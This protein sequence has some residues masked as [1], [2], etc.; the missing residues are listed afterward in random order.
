MAENAYVYKEVICS[1]GS[2]FCEYQYK[3]RYSG[4]RVSFRAYLEDLFEFG[5]QS[6]QL[7]LPPLR[8]VDLCLESRDD[9]V[10]GQRK[11]I[12]VLRDFRL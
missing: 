9:L 8:G 10:F 7:P 11:P 4:R 12:F 1:L 3:N 5:I 6:I 2:S